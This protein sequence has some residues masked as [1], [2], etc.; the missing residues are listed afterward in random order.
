MVKSFW[1]LA[2]A[3]AFLLISACSGGGASSGPGPTPAPPAPPSGFAASAVG[4]TSVTLGWTA[5]SSFASYRI[6]RNNVEIGTSTGSSFTDTGLAPGTSYQYFVRGVTSGGVLS[7]ASPTITVTTTGGANA[8]TLAQL[9]D[10]AARSFMMVRD[11]EFDAAGNIFVAGG[12]FSANFPTTA[13]AYDRTFG[14]GGSSTGSNG[15][16]D[17]FVMKFNRSGQLLWSTLVGGP[18][19]DRAYGLEIAPDGGVV[20]AGRAGEG[21]PTTAGVI[22]PTFAGDT[23][24]NGAYGKQDGFVAK[25]SADGSTL[26]W[27]T[28]FG[29]S[30]SGFLRDVGVDANNKV[31]VAG[32]MFA[33][34]AHITA[35]ALQQTPKGQHDL[36]YARLNPTATAVEY[37]TYIGGNEPAGETQGTPSIFVTPARDVY[38]AIEEG[39][40]GAP[41]TPGAFQANNAGGVDFLIAKFSPADQLVYATYLGGAGDEDLETHNIAVDS[42]GRLALGS[43]S[44]STNYP[45]TSGAFRQTYGGGV[46]DG[47]VSIL[48]ASGSALAASTYFG[49]N[50]TEDLQGVEFAPN[51]LLYFSGGTGSSGISTS[52]G[53]FQTNFAGGTDA[54]L[55]GMATD[56]KTMPFFSYLGGTDLESARAMDV[57]ADGAIAFGGVTQSPNFPVLAGGS[58]A[59]NG[60]ATT[61]WFALKTP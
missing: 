25:L 18:N 44:S 7:T 45:V 3:F 23:A 54:F 10:P 36:V 12:A 53:A 6:F 30:K 43:I 34:V 48:S 15:P 46:N 47:V 8:L 35:N 28:Y 41:T 13:G 24:P 52:S 49:G 11:I 22:Q 20:I 26:L 31:Y 5:S 19:H 21:F 56:L 16:A 33:G 17:A 39:G 32:A 59:P 57:G 37:A 27:S 58:T 2:A 42:A 50:G 40:N 61:G 29:S 4:N 51:G 60:G 14:S 1:S 55:A 9:V 38:L